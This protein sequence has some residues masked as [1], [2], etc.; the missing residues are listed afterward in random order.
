[1]LGRTG[2]EI[3]GFGEDF[4]GGLIKPTFDLYIPLDD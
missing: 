1:M 2:T 3:G 4:N